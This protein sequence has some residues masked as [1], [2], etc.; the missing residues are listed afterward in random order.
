MALLDIG[1]PES[2]ATRL[3]DAYAASRARAAVRSSSRSTGWGQD[4]D[5]RRA[6]EAGFDEHLVKPV[7]LDALARALDLGTAREVMGTW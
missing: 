5:R 7:E 6:R 3:R 1:M 2:T 4:E